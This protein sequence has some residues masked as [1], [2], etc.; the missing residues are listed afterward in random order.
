MATFSLVHGAWGFGAQWDLVRAELE[1]HGHVVHTPDLPCEEI[2]AGVD[3]YAAAVPACDVVVGHS[4][5]GMTIPYVAAGT[6][7]FLCAL[8]AGAI[9][10]W[11]DV[12][13]PG[14]GAGRLRDDLGR[15]YYPDP[16]VAAAETQYPPELAHLAAG[17]RRQAPYEAAPRPVAEPVY[18]VCTEDAVIRPEWQR[19]AARDVLGVE[20]IELEAGHMPMLECPRELAELLDGIAGEST[21]IPI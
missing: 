2:G 19:H 10:E 3:E 12:F 18:V 21:A 9:A 4:L 13:G 1:A 14:F 16:A 11:A 7:V 5:G 8:V 20:P 15:S 17:I 6:H